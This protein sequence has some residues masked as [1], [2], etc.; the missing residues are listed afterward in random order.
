MFDTLLAS[1][2]SRLSWIRSAVIALALHAGF[3]A[4]VTGG[5]RPYEVPL[6]RDTI[7]VDL[8]LAQAFRPLPRVQERHGS[9]DSWMPPPPVIPRIHLDRPLLDLRAPTALPG[10][11]P[12]AY[13]SLPSLPGL[14]TGRE[15][16]LADSIFPLANVDRPP[17]LAAQVRPRY[18][19]A[20]RGSGLHGIVELEY[21]VTQDGRVDGATMQVTTS[22]HRAFAEAAV[23]AL[24]TARFRPALR[25]GRPVAVRVR[26][27]VRF[28]SR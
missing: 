5:A 6:P 26:Q 20:L 8:R 21:V 3:V 4:S 11:P 16:R 7:R 19:E 15:L 25:N 27:S 2:V 28:V 14:P 12:T 24:L 9:P 23:N 13:P 18:P 17:E 22:S 1:R 10:A